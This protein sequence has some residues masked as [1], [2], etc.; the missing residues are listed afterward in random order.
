VSLPSQRRSGVIRLTLA[1]IA[2]AVTGYPAQVPKQWQPPAWWAQ[3]AACIRSHEG[4]WTAN[5]GNGYYGAY[6]F[7]LST[8][9]AVGGQGYP[10]Q[11]S[12]RE[13]NYRAWLNWRANGS[14]WG[15]QWGTASAC[16]LR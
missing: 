10:H 13:Q 6:Q 2:I 12:P 1:T 5:T 14:R 3:Q 9:R 4:W 8:W 15:G 11:A 7:L 16:G